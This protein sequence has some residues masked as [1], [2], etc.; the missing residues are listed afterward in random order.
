VVLSAAAGFGSP[1][2]LEWAPSDRAASCALCA[3][4][5]HS[6]AILAS[7]CDVSITVHLADVLKVSPSVRASVVI[8][9]ITCGRARHG[10]RYST[11]VEPCSRGVGRACSRR[12]DGTAGIEE[13]SISLRKSACNLRGLPGCRA[14]CAVKSEL[15]RSGLI[16]RQAVSDPHGRHGTFSLPP[17]T[18]SARANSVGSAHP[19]VVARWPIASLDSSVSRPMRATI[20]VLMILIALA[21]WWH[22]LYIYRILENATADPSP[23]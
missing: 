20:A 5:R 1:S 14:R 3:V 8:S 13:P 10:Q 17:G 2:R 18:A 19:L 12:L 16:F 11:A 7:G 6:C 15:V 9:T 21:T 23:I 4:T 22:F